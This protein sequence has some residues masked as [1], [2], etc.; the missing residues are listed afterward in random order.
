MKKSYFRAHCFSCSDTRF[1]GFQPKLHFNKAS[2]RDFLQQGAV[3]G[4]EGRARVRGEQGRHG[5]KRWAEH[6]NESWGLK[7]TN[8]QEEVDR[9][10]LERQL[11]HCVEGGDF[12]R[13]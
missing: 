10:T 11:V 13:S 9:T 7:M 12:F 1:S 2:L 3:S 6:L 5:K 8:K 4:W